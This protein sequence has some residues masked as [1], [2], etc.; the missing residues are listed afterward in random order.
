[1]DDYAE[2]AWRELCGRAQ[3][4]ARTGVSAVWRGKEVKD[5]QGRTQY[6]YTVFGAGRGWYGRMHMVTADGA[7]HDMRVLK[8]DAQVYELHG[9]ECKGVTVQLLEGLDVRFC[10]YS[11]KGGTVCEWRDAQQLRD[12]Y[13][14]MGLD[15]VG[16]VIVEV[17]E[18]QLCE[19]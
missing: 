10:D 8:L 3:R 18:S 9:E 7:R 17:D 4:A 6:M 15:E 14:V 1:M 13:G 5:A 11:K 19:Q 2:R 12:K 16:M